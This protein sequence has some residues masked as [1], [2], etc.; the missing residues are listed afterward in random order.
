MK[1]SQT[2]VAAT[3]VAGAGLASVALAGGGPPPAPSAV[4]PPAF[5]IVATAE[6]RGR[7]RAPAPR[8]DATITR[9]VRKARANRLPAAL[10]SAR[11]EAAMLGA[12]TALRPGRIVG[13]RRDV[14]PM[15]YWGQDEGRFGPGIWCGRIYT[16]RRT[17]KRP[18]GSTRRVNRYRDGCQPPRDTTVRVTVTFAAVPAT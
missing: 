6:A 16:G 10:A 2:V 13:V 4:D 7:V 9:A 18:D 17:L 1:L 8:T 5:T 15:G 12:A 3:A 14:S 11:A